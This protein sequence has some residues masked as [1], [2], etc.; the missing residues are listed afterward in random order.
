MGISRGL[1]RG[2]IGSFLSKISNY[3]PVL[4]FLILSTFSLTFTPSVHA[5][6]APNAVLYDTSGSG[7]AYVDNN[8]GTT[9]IYDA[10]GNP[11]A[12]VADTGAV[13]SF[14]GKQ[15]GWYD[16]GVVYDLNGFQ[17]AFS[18]TQVPNT[19]V[20][21]RVETGVPSY[22][23]L[24]N[25]TVV[26]TTTTTVTKPSFTPKVSPDPFSSVFAISPAP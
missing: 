3:L 23:P 12:Y 22:K 7:V 26:T 4:I 14:G 11:M 6:G 24:P 16:N 19:V 17:L 1:I 15:L 20:V 2:I 21:K 13:Y 9:V 18:E 5:Q 8:N 10:A 25:R